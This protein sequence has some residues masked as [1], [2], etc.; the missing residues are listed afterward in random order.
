MT[1][2]KNN[3]LI[4]DLAAI[5]L[6]ILL[7]VKAES[8][9]KKNILRVRFETATIKKDVSDI[10]LNV[11]YKIEALR[12]PVNFHGYECRFS[13]DQ[14]KIRP[15][16]VFFDG[17]ASQGGT[18]GGNNVVATG[19]YRIE[20]LSTHTLDTTNPVLFQVRYSVKGFAD[21]AM[22]AP[23]RFDVLS[24]SS[25]I[26]TVIIENAPGR[27]QVSWY[28][29]A[30]LYKDNTPPPPIPKKV[31]IAL[32]SDSTDIQSDSIKVISLKVVSPLDSANIKSGIFEFDL[33]T[34]AFDSVAVLKGALLSFANLTVGR[35]TTHITAS[36]SSTD[37][38]SGSG[39]LLKIVL[40][41]KA[42][43]DTICT[44]I[45]NPKFTVFNAG[46]RDSLIQYRLQGICVLGVAP[47]DTTH[48]GIAE[49]MTNKDLA[50]A[51]FP[52]PARSFID[53]HMS[54]GQRGKKHLEVFDALGRKVFDRIFEADLRWEVASV[55]AG[56]YTATVTDFSALQYGIGLE[57]T[58]ILII[59]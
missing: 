27:D 20:L 59:H 6:I 36:F 34:A 15:N 56:C 45:L 51:I 23:T 39:E 11:F 21:S 22:I 30:L 57:K 35:D 33:D 16:T 29:F 53:F 31:N 10:V 46:H 1:V 55:S 43:T 24:E 40:R 8:A 37:S 49:L 54:S 58:K 19:E 38:L 18:G 28:P 26:D 25:G 2:K 4:F 32:L 48:K 3:R 14:T 7:S 12:S 52:N 42:R 41:G 44:G 9:Q 17:T 13:Y 50:V 47:K 5:L